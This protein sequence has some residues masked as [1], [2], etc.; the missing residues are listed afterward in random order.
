MFEDCNSIAEI[1]SRVREG[2]FHDDASEVLRE[3]QPAADT[4]AV[5]NSEDRT[6]SYVDPAWTDRELEDLTNQDWLLIAELLSKS[7]RDPHFAGLVG[8]AR[9]RAG[10]LARWALA[11]TTSDVPSRDINVGWRLEAAPEP[12]EY[13]FFTHSSG[14]VPDLPME[15]EIR[16]SKHK[17]ER[18][19]FLNTLLPTTPKSGPFEQDYLLVAGV[20]L[21][22]FSHPFPLSAYCSPVWRALELT[23][24]FVRAADA[25]A[26]DLHD[27]TDS[28]WYR[29]THPGE[30]PWNRLTE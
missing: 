7:T 20:L 3:G 9:G 11:T 17:L 10:S 29:R 4:D 22:H 16:R 14:Y 30:A 24:V 23:S 15:E 5:D 13:W 2:P 26:G 18:P 28:E 1:R 12:D 27:A 25:P 19:I 21:E 6:Q 8:D